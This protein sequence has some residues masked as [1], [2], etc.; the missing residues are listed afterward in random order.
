MMRAAL[1]AALLLVSGVAYGYVD[2]VY[3]VGP[4]IST[5]A[6]GVVKRQS[7]IQAIEG[8]PS[9]TLVPEATSDA[10]TSSG[11]DPV[12]YFGRPAPS[13]SKWLGF[14]WHTGPSY[15]VVS[16]T[17]F[18]SFYPNASCLFIYHSGHYQGFFSAAELA[19]PSG[20][21]DFMRRIVNEAHCDVLLVSM[22]MMGLNVTAG[23]YIGY[24]TVPTDI[25]NIMGTFAAGSG[26]PVR[27]FLDDVP[28]SI[29][30]ALNRKS[31][32]KI[33]MAGLSG[34]GWTTTVMAALDPR[35]THS[36]A[37]AGSVPA[38]SRKS[39]DWG[40]WEQYTAIPQLDVDYSDLYLMSTLDASGNVT[41]KG[42]MI[43]NT[44]DSCCFNR[45]AYAGWAPF[46]QDYS[47]RHGFGD[48][49]FYAAWTSGHDV[50]P[51]TAQVILN[52][53]MQ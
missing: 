16:W 40:D 13:V 30:W 7:M 1:A 14:Y 21:R 46:V 50:L 11:A 41:R 29:T 24:P 3:P 18:A 53:F 37:V 44:D 35:I 51:W 8:G 6:E 15:G 33:G 22:P 34:G 17:Y 19:A 38:W 47:N 28:G 23:T 27:Y 10:N 25:H 39:I 45:D 48:V 20:A 12:A 9:F 5:S 32:A 36:Y 43:Y 52:D 49:K 26:K 31:Y 2:W 4:T 42:R